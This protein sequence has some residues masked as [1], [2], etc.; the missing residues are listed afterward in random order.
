MV[1]LALHVVSFTHPP[2]AEGV[3]AL[4]MC[5]WKT[6]LSVSQ[7]VTLLSLGF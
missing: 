3:T 5:M 7:V 2:G 1:L 4:L 6:E